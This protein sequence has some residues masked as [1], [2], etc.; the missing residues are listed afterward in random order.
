M[1]NIELKVMLI[2]DGIYERRKEKN[3]KNVVNM[4]YVN[5][6]GKN[7]QKYMDGMNLFL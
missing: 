2:I 4:I 6:H 7:I 5:D 1:Q 3:A